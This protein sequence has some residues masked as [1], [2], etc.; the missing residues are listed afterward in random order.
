[1]GIDSMTRKV[2]PK[3]GRQKV[4]PPPKRR[5]KRPEGASALED[6]EFAEFL[7]ADELPVNADP[8]FKEK[9]RR[10][11]WKLLKDLQGVWLLLLGGVTRLH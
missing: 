10:K 2:D 1:M 9:L 7:E 8:E 3:K 4:A 11:L 5:S 6:E